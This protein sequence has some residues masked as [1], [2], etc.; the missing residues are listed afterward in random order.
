[1]PGKTADPVDMTVGRNVR[2]QRIAAGLTQEEL[3]RRIGVT[4]QQVQKYEKGTNRI[5]VSRLSRIAGV[6]EVPILLLFEGVAA[7][8]AGAQT[9]AG[10]VAGETRSLRLAQAFASIADADLRGCIVDL[11]E[12]I[13]SARS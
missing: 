13:A 1:M 4:Y 11:I 8:P 3:G 10:E 5:G 12:R 7:L 2:L 6:L 9:A